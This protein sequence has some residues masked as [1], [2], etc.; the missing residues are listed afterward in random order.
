M[1]KSALALFNAQL[2]VNLRLRFIEE[3]VERIPPLFSTETDVV[4]SLQ[5]AVSISGVD[6]LSDDAIPPPLLS[7]VSLGHLSYQDA[8][9]TPIEADIHGII[10]N[11]FFFTDDDGWTCYRRTSFSCICSYAISRPPPWSANAGVQFVR[12]ADQQHFQVYGFAMCI[13][14]VDICDLPVELVQIGPKKKAMGAPPRKHLEKVRL[15]PKTPQIFQDAAD[16]S[17]GGKMTSQTNM[18]DEHRFDR[19]Q[20]KRAP[21]NGAN[22]SGSMQQYYRLVIELWAD[23]GSQHTDQFIMVAFRPSILISC[24]EF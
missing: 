19:I 10:D 23:I 14:A 15:A 24:H 8:E 1:A 12:S 18:S 21:G 11:G 3:S 4:K 22:K 6:P 16:K 17:T 2:T 20:F 13:S 7:M 5:E 9:Q